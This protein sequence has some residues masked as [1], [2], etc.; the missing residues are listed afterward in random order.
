MNSKKKQDSTHT[1]F[2]NKSI[3]YSATLVRKVGVASYRTH[4]TAGAR[5]FASG[6]RS[7]YVEGCGMLHRYDTTFQCC[8]HFLSFCVAAPDTY[9]LHRLNSHSLA[10]ATPL[11][12]R[13]SCDQA[14][15]YLTGKSESLCRLSVKL[16][17]RHNIIFGEVQLR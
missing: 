13:H 7:L 15:K 4:S 6:W 3:L 9:R 16:Q 1:P 17:T 14:N 10:V 8:F 11:Q 2:T 12:S 5:Q